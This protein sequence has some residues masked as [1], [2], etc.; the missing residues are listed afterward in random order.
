MLLEDIIDQFAV[1]YQLGVD[2]ALEIM[3]SE[4][5]I[6]HINPNIHHYIIYKIKK[7][8]VQLQVQWEL[9]GIEMYPRQLLIQLL[10]NHQHF[11]E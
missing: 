4:M 9:I 8:D 2:S 1:H 7:R 3:N 10:R 11:K 6:P 5:L